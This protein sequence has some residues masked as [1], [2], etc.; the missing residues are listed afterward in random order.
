M[1]NML[2][3][4]DRR[5]SS[6]NHFLSPGRIPMRKHILLSSGLALALLGGVALHA[7]GPA[8][9]HAA[10]AQH[11]ST[12]V[13][14]SSARAGVHILASEPVDAETDANTPCGAD[15]TGSQIGDCQDSATTAGPADTAG[16]TDEIA[17]TSDTDTV[18]SGDPNSAD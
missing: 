15:A 1:P 7:T 5:L 14:A 11:A 6:E 3:K 16:S 12:I 4:S 13:V 10:I 18:Q 8:T 2:E 17:A 9:A